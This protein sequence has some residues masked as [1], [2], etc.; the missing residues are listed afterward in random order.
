MIQASK[1]YVMM[2]LENYAKN[3]QQIELLQCELSSIGLISEN[4][5]I[6]ALTFSKGDGVTTSTGHVSDKTA[7]IAMRYRD[8]INEMNEDTLTAVINQLRPLKLQKDRLDRCIG[9]LTPIHNSIISG[10][11]IQSRTVKDLLI[12]ITGA[13][14]NVGVLV[15]NADIA[16]VGVFQQSAA[17]FF[18]QFCICIHDIHLHFYIGLP[19]SYHISLPL[20]RGEF[21]ELTV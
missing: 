9:L 19:L 21:G 5:M 18:D 14:Y 1:S 12:D 2:C 10:L 8:M 6:E 13:P 20:E 15:D 17:I 7:S 16:V 4:E 11:Y 3:E